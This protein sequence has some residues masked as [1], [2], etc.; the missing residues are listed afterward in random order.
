MTLESG[1]WGEHSESSTDGEESGLQDF[2]ANLAAQ[3]T[4]SGVSI[5]D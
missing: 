5:C 4:S 1:A 2:V 3:C